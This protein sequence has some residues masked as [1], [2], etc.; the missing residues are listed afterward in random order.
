MAAQT[1]AVAAPFIYATGEEVLPLGGYTG[2]IPSPTAAEM[3]SFVTARQFHLALVAAP[4]VTPGAAYV[5][6]RC[7]HVRSRSAPGPAATLEDLLLPGPRRQ[8]ALTRLRSRVHT[9]ACTMAR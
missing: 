7:L 9:Y 1:S 6:A 4:E 5:V 2:V 8:G 3:Q